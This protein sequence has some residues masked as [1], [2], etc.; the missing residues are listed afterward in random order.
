VKCL[1]T[2]AHLIEE[3]GVK[4]RAMM[5]CIGKNKLVDKERN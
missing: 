2:A 3:V 4:L 1:R 5:P